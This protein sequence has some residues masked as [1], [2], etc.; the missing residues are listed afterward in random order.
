LRRS[1]EGPERA[2]SRLTRSYFLAFIVRTNRDVRASRGA[3]ARAPKIVTVAARRT[4]SGASRARRRARGERML[5]ERGSSEGVHL[6]TRSHEITT[7]ARECGRAADAR[8]SSGRHTRKEALPSLCA[9]GQS[10]WSC[11]GSNDATDSLRRLR[12]SN[13]LLGLGGWAWR[14]NLWATSSR[15]DRTNVFSER[16]E[17]TDA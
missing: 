2:L 3:Y 1:G 11:R 12:R 10:N 16:R 8:L 6:R 9:R 4:S 14:L 17:T 7:R 15:Q 5:A 13:K